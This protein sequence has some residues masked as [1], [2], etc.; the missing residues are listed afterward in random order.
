LPSIKEI[1]IDF[2]ATEIDYLML[3]SRLMRIDYLFRIALN[4]VD[5]RTHRAFHTLHHLTPRRALFITF[6]S[7]HLTHFAFTL[8]VLLFDVI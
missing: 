6:G 2:T 7:R 5:T 4:E 3:F 8:A 1:L